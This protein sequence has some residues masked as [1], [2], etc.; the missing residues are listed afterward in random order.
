MA[1]AFESDSDEKGTGGHLQQ[2]TASDVNELRQLLDQ[3]NVHSPTFLQDAR[4][5]ACVTEKYTIEALSNS[6]DAIVAGDALV[7]LKLAY[8]MLAN[9]ESFGGSETSVRLVGLRSWWISLVFTRSEFRIPEMTLC[10]LDQHSEEIKPL[11]MANRYTNELE[12]ELKRLEAAGD[13]ATVVM[14]GQCYVFALNCVTWLDMMSRRFPGAFACTIS[15]RNDLFEKLCKSTLER[16]YLLKLGV[17]DNKTLQHCSLLLRHWAKIARGCKQYTRSL[18]ALLSKHKFPTTKDAGQKRKA[19][20]A[21]AVSASKRTATDSTHVVPLV[22][23]PAHR[24]Q[25]VSTV[26]IHV[27]LENSAQYVE[28][29]IA[30]ASHRT[31]VM[32]SVAW[33]S[34]R[35]I[36]AALQHKCLL[37]VLNDDDCNQKSID[38]KVVDPT[39]LLHP[40]VRAFSMRT[41]KGEWRR[42]DCDVKMAKH[43]TSGIMHSKLIVFGDLLYQGL[44]VAPSSLATT[45][46]DAEDF[47]F[48]PLEIINGSFNFT[49]SAMGQ[50][51]IGTFLGADNV[52]TEYAEKVIAHAENARSAQ[53]Q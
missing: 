2:L 39:A 3:L 43:G 17:A 52:A 33:L 27:T 1:D 41:S 13:S 4:R 47:V 49:E 28:Q 10:R 36:L 21:A 48:R 29:I 40:G 23:Q 46:G 6:V 50:T 18:E 15:V 25:R 22:A 5:F 34:H 38:S 37:V 45:D 12:G 8:A 14:I 16:D 51:N 30:Y 53:Q 31:A 11:Q 42:V 32:L 7:A 9:R 35:G 44:I 26:D 24:P 19:G 20:T